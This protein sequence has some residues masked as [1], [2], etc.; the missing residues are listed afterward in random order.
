MLVP[1]HTHETYGFNEAQYGVISEFYAYVAFFIVLLTFGMETTLFRFVNKHEDKEK[2]FNQAASFVILL[3]G[4]FFITVLVFSGNIASWMGYPEMQNFV[5]WFGAILAV[6]A[7]SS[8]FLAKLRFQN[9]AKKFAIV[10]LA[11]IAVNIL[12]NLV[13]ILGFYDAAQPDL[14]MGIGFVFLANLA[15]SIIK[16][17]ILFKEVRLYR[18]VW[19]KAMSKAM[20]LFALPLAIAGFAGIINET[21]D[22]ILIKR[23]MMGGGSETELEFAQSQVGIYSANYKL[24]VLITLFIQ[25]FRFAA[26]P[27]FFEQEK[28]QDKDKVY[29]KVMTYFVIVV[30][31]MFLVISLNLDIF[32]WFI[33]NEA[34][35]EGLTVVPLLLMAN[36]CLGIYYNQSIWYKLADKT[37]YGAYIAIAGAAITI[38]LNL[39]LIP[40]LG[41][42]GAAWTTFVCYFSMMVMSY[43]FGK[44]IYPIKYNMRKI[45]LYTISAFFLWLIGYGLTFDSFWITFL[46]HNIL[47]LLFIS[48]VLFMERPFQ[49]LRKR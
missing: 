28:N 6:D 38:G 31:L 8:L 25:A 21:L 3:S 2:V 18:F 47:V 43:Y 41:Y 10:Q 36:V 11:S 33:P 35:H 5:T 24:S 29:S 17:L 27:F 16:P 22:R 26:E 49:N 9:K 20:F 42:A 37:I 39:V 7:V 4:I 15:A 45:G 14:S 40:W 34:F 12:L 13:L 44:K 30:S 46:F 1:L 19:D 23:L 48:I 32:K